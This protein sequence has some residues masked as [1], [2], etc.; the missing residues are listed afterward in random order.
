MCLSSV[1]IN[2]RLLPKVANCH[3]RFAKCK[4]G[5]DEF[6]GTSRSSSAEGGESLPRCAE[7]QPVEPDHG[8]YGTEWALE[9][10]RGTSDCILHCVGCESLQNAMI[11]AEGLEPMTCFNVVRQLPLRIEV[12]FG[13]AI[14]FQ[15]RG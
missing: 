2:R 9:T 6:V 11:L 14:A 8:V 5:H 12:S 3:D 7:I 1:P 13:I 10:D 15:R 4:T